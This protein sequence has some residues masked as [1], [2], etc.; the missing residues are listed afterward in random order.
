MMKNREAQSKP[1]RFYGRTLPDLGVE[2]AG[3]SAGI[4]SDAKDESAATFYRKY[5]F[6]ELPKIEKRLFV[7][8]GNR[9]ANVSEGEVK[10]SA[11]TPRAFC[12]AVVPIAPSLGS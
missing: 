10:L 11:A 1:F 2:Q 3:A 9:G 5:G 6:M 7:P 8:N 4:I 12:S